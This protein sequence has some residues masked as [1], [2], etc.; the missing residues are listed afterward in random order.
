M[1]HHHEPQ[2]ALQVYLV[3]KKQGVIAEQVLAATL[4][5]LLLLTIPAFAQKAFLTLGVGMIAPITLLGISAILL[6]RQMNCFS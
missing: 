3:L 1:V 5:A 4:G 6:L 2:S